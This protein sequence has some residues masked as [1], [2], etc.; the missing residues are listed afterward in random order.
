MHW[1]KQKTLKPIYIK[2]N[3]GKDYA[4]T[5]LIMIIFRWVKYG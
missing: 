2:I 4:N 1:N 5:L 3:T